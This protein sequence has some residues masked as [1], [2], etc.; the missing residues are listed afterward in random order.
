VDSILD[1]SIPTMELEARAGLSLEHV[2][3]GL[4]DGIVSRNFSNIKPRKESI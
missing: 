1:R 4:N 3:S 2:P